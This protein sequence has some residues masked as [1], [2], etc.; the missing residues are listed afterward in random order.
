MTHR[1]P[2]IGMLGAGAER[3]V[4]H[5]FR[6]LEGK[7]FEWN[8]MPTWSPF[9]V[10]QARGEQHFVHQRSRPGGHARGRHVQGA[11]GGC[12][13]SKVFKPPPRLFDHLRAAFGLA[14]TGGDL[15]HY[16]H[17]LVNR[18]RVADIEYGD[19]GA[20]IKCLRVRAAAI[21][22]DN[23]IRSEH[24]HVFRRRPHRRQ[25][26]GQVSQIRKLSFRIPGKRENALGFD[27]LEHVLIGAIVQADDSHGSKVA[28][29]RRRAVLCIAGSQQERQNRRNR[30][31][32]EVSQNRTRAPTLPERPGTP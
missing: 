1:A 23:E 24:K 12:R 4:G 28:H 25:A 10:L 2:G 18:V 27:K 29:L 26:C 9:I 16:R 6:H 7:P 13:F 19:S 5:Q 15:R 32:H 31:D 20:G 17:Y 11:Q 3:R 14:E 21:R 8:G 22:T 30:S